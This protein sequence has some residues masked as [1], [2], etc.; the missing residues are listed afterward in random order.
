MFAVPNPVP[1][2]VATNEVGGATFIDTEVDGDEYTD[3][4]P[5][6]DAT[7]SNVYAPPGVSPETEAVLPETVYAAR[8]YAAELRDEYTI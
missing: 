5:P 4:I 2:S 6:L 1:V 8:M 7:I 3:K